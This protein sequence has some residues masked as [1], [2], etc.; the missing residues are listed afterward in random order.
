M[1]MVMVWRVTVLVFLFCLTHATAS[2]LAA[3]RHTPADSGQA[4]AEA[5]T[6][7]THGDDNHNKLS[8]PLDDPGV[9]FRSKSNGVLVYRQKDRRLLVFRRDGNPPHC[10]EQAEVQCLPA[11]SPPPQVAFLGQRISDAGAACG[12]ASPCA[13]DDAP[14]LSYIRSMI[15]GA[16]KFHEKS[17][18]GRV[19]SIGLGAGSIPLW[20][21]HNLPDVQV[22]A[23]DVNPD[24]IEAAPCFGVAPSPKMN[25]IEA[26]GRAYLENLPNGVLDVVFVD[27][28]DDQDHVPPCLRTVEFF[29]LAQQKLAPG[30][31]LVMNSW[32]RDADKIRSSMAHG[33]QKVKAPVH[34]GSSPGLGNLI[35]LTQS[36][37]GVQKESNDEWDDVMCGLSANKNRA[38]ASASDWACDADFKKAPTEEGDPEFDEQNSCS[39]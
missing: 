6:V 19:A 31:V 4:S 24:V 15:G 23:I 37:G 18:L 10:H 8:L 5:C 38:D 13:A 28:F 20:F 11:D 14:G 35:L 32:H 3:R 9:E 30:G 27:A 26:D 34:I 21:S 17:R 7:V 12:S 1:V 29:S 2:R 22:D 39:L 36:P 33:F 16:L 25:L